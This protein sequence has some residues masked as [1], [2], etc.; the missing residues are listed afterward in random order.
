M[1]APSV[2]P[3]LPAPMPQDIDGPPC[4]ECLT[5]GKHAMISPKGPKCV[6]VCGRKNKRKGHKSSRCQSLVATGKLE[7][8]MIANHAYKGV[9]KAKDISG[10]DEKLH[11]YKDVGAV[12]F[13]LWQVKSGTGF[14][15]IIATDSVAEAKAFDDAT[16]GA[17]KDAEKKA[18]DDTEANIQAPAQAPAETTKEVVAQPMSN[19]PCAKESPKEGEMQEMAPKALMERAE[20]REK[21]SKQVGA[22]GMSTDSG[23][24]MLMARIE[25]LEAQVRS[26]KATE[27][28][29]R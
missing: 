4:G 19:K 21:P 10:S 23:I 6:L 3:R 16:N 27:A 9:R 26:Q 20:G 15:N 28:D 25:A 14:D 18:F 24:K 22:H 8:P 29:L 5:F 13:N 17:T 1:D 12:A 11:V 7:A 2:I